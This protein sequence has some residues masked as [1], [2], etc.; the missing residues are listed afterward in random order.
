MTFNCWT[1][2]DL[3]TQPVVRGSDLGGPDRVEVTLVVAVQTVDAL[4]GA[5]SSLADQLSLQ[6]EYSQGDHWVPFQGPC[7]PVELTLAEI[8]RRAAAVSHDPGMPWLDAQR[9]LVDVRRRLEDQTH[10]SLG[11][12]PVRYLQ[13]TADGLPSGE[14]ARCTVTLG[15]PGPGAGTARA[16]FWLVAPTFAPEDLRCSQARGATP[17]A[18]LRDQDHWALMSRTEGGLQHLRLDL[19][20]TD[21]GEFGRPGT[22]LVPV[23]LELS[24][25]S[26]P[27]TVRTTD[28][29]GYPEGDT[30]DRSFLQAVVDRSTDSVL[31]TVHRA[32]HG[33]VEH[34]VVTTGGD[35]H[36]GVTLTDTTPPGQRPVAVMIIQFCIQGLN[37]LFTTPCE[38]YQ[39]PRDYI[40]ITWSDEDAAYS[41]KPQARENEVP[42]GY[43]FSI[44]A[45]A[46]YGIRTHWAFNAGSLLLLQ[47]GLSSDQFGELTDRVAAGTL[48]PQNAGYGGHR[49]KYYQFETNR[50]EIAEGYD[51]IQSLL[52]A[53]PEGHGPRLYFPDQRLYAAQPT[54]VE[55]YTRLRGQEQLQYLVLDRSTVC[56]H[57]EDG[58]HPYF[59]NGSPQGDDGNYLWTDE[60]TGLDLLLIEDQLRDEML[61]ASAEEVLR[62]QLGYY[63]RRRFLRAV[64][65]PADGAS[66]LY[67]YADDAEHSAANGWFDG[68]DDRNPILFTRAYLAAMH[69]FARHPWMNVTTVDDFQP[70]LYQ[71]AGPAGTLQVSSSID[72]TL[73]PRGA[74]SVDYFGARLHFDTW[75]HAWQATRS[76]WLDLSLFEITDAIEQALVAASPENEEPDPTDP[77]RDLVDLAWLHFLLGTHESFWSQQP[78]N[79]HMNADEHHW[80][81]EDFAVSESLQIRNAWTHLNAAVWARLRPDLPAR[82]SWAIDEEPADHD[83]H[84][85][86]LGA[87]VAAGTANPHWTRTPDERQ[88]GRYADHDNLATYLLYNDQLLLVV[89]Q[90]GGR[91]VNLYGFN[92]DRVVSLSGSAKSHQFLTLAPPREIPG[93]GPRIDNNPWSPNHAYLA[94]DVRQ[95][96]PSLVAVHDDRRADTD[97]PDLGWLPDLFNRYACSVDRTAA[98]PEIVCRYESDPPDVPFRLEAWEDVEDLLAEDGRALREGRPGVVRHPFE[99]FEKRIR[100]EGCDVVVSYSGVQPGH[101]VSN[102]LS[103]DLLSLLRGGPMPHVVLAG[104]GRSVRLGDDSS[105][106]TV[107]LGDNCRFASSAGPSAGRGGPAELP[108]E[109]FCWD[110]HGRTAR[111]MSQDLRIVC[112]DGGS[113]S[114]RVELG[115][116]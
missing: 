108:G 57:G 11:A 69:W 14:L 40:Q 27:A 100:L 38:D 74:E 26:G 34:V 7:T 111:I 98:T 41:S 76:S 29:A 71:H 72:A 86:L 47:H 56:H 73:D 112:P 13:I 1:C 60:Q 62:G 115:L 64:A 49:P 81:V 85:P 52:P 43:R 91:V 65:H 63:L 95:A 17:G 107:R 78:W 16:G 116:R 54:E 30:V 83:R 42:D 106:V 102:E 23:E 32:S 44:L 21:D 50:R 53:R 84:G 109:R 3:T 4:L 25:A 22:G 89:D 39:P 5:P 9:H 77:G 97:N 67:V 114:Y 45:E 94:A 24:T 10:R 82:S 93:D 51:L 105:A 46:A 101:L 75:Y 19:L 66:K 33:P 35:Q 8:T 70:E 28:G 113:F 79:D 87:L 68:G 55:P 58:E 104:D 18:W 96:Q 59:G 48:S 80:A 92:G 31:V 36:T 110:D 99:P 12:L 88:Q 37:D 15:K 103:P 2:S 90:N 6:L 20:L 61:N